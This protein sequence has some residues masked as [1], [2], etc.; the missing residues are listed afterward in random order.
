YLD[1][2]FTFTVSDGYGTSV[3]QE[4]TLRIDGSN[5][6]PLSSGVITNAPSVYRSFEISDT[7]KRLIVD[8]SYHPT[9]PG[10]NP[11]EFQN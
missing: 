6:G 10:R 2:S 9:I 8:Q 4:L 3:V 11:S 1:E 5:D 7:W